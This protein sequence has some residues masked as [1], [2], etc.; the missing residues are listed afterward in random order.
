M[1]PLI[2]DRWTGALRV[3]TP[4]AWEFTIEAWG[5]VFFSWQHEFDAKFGAGLRDLQS[6]ILEGAA[7][8]EKAAARANKKD[9]AALKKF[10]GALRSADAEAAHVLAHDPVLCGMM[11]VYAD[12]SLATAA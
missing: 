9:A 10:S 6:E 3:T 5:D 7:F 11:T 1:R 8:V 2:N 12:R 4:G